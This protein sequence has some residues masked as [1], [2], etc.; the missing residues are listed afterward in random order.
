MRNYIYFFFALFI[1]G[2][3]SIKEVSIN[4]V[5]SH[6][7]VVTTPILVKKDTIYVN[8]LRFYKIKS[9]RDGMKLMYLNFGK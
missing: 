5:N 2:C 9:A 8:E 7:K 3:L 6:F 1:F 4:K